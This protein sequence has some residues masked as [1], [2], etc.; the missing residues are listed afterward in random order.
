MRDKRKSR[1]LRGCRLT[2]SALAIG[3]FTGVPV[4]AATKGDDLKTPIKHVIVIIGE[5]RSFDHV[6]ATYVPKKAGE[7]VDNLLS[8]GIIQLDSNMNAVKG[9]KFALA[10]QNSAQDS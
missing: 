5:N 9:P 8:K 4:R 6:F 7:T 10:Q 2:L 1:W 3:Q